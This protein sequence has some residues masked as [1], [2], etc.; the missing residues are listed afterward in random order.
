MD[1]KINLQTLNQLSIIYISLPLLTFLA[2]WLKPY[3]AIISFILFMYAIYRG[4]FKDK[5]FNCKSLLNSRKVFIIAFI[6]SLL[7]CYF[8]G[9]GGFWYQSND[10]HWRNAIFR[11]LINYNWPVYYKTINVAMVYYIGFWLPAA[12]IVKIISFF[13]PLSKYLSFFIGNELLFIYGTVGLF[14]VFTNILFALKVKRY[15][16]VLLAILIFVLFSGLDIVGAVTPVFY[17]TTVVF[18]KLHLEWWSYIGQYSSNTTVL[19]WVFNQGIPAWIIT[20]MFYNNRKKIENYG[21]LALLCF[22]CAPL[23]FIGLSVLLISYFIKN[24]FV[25]YRKN[26]I[27]NYLKKTFS[28]QN[29]VTVIFITPIIFLY[30]ISNITAAATIS[31]A[32]VHHQV[33]WKFWAIACM[34]IYFIFLEALVYLLPLYKQYKKTIMY[35]VVFVFLVLCP[36]L[37]SG[38]KVDFCMRTP[39]PIFVILSLFVMRFLFRKY[40]RK[41]FK[42][43]YLFLCLCLL[44]GSIT[45]I[46]EF[47][48]GFKIVSENK[49]V[50]ESADQLRS[51][52]N[53]INYDQYGNV[54]SG[55]FVA[56][57]PEEQIFF[58]YLSKKK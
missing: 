13:Q 18:K 8:S 56:E 42:M 26:K 44:L 14:L 41:R 24:L 10:Y 52:E 28:A 46:F 22:F 45:P 50:F 1:L 48:R 47:S 4:Y 5:E 27:F 54:I 23:P 11:D 38:K 34:F 19:F 51:L 55:N 7:W 30:F 6:I 21:I 57:F 58:K 2:T 40:N 12:L 3:I 39:I 33:F 20:L 25:E 36:I 29:I 49:T 9:M 15:S 43:R 35:Y 37:M 16:K 53:I 31:G 17:D 32:S